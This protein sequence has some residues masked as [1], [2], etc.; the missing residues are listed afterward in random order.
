MPGLS[1]KLPNTGRKE[2]NFSGCC[3]IPVHRHTARQTIAHFFV[4][5]S[6]WICE[7]DLLNLLIY[8]FCSIEKSS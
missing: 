4:L 7:G 6:Q 3:C 1:I 2:D 5:F 8:F